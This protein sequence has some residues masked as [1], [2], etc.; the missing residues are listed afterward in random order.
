M[1]DTGE[2]CRL[3]SKR[4]GKGSAQRS[5]GIQKYMARQFRPRSFV[6]TRKWEEVNS[7]RNQ[8]IYNHVKSIQRRQAISLLL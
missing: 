1:V 7:T 3:L 6:V 2:D 4:R 5:S 8:D